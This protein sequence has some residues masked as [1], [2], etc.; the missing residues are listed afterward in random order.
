MFTNHRCTGGLSKNKRHLSRFRAKRLLNNR[1]LRYCS[2]N[3]LNGDGEFRH[4]AAN[5]ANLVNGASRLVNLKA[6]QLDIN[7]N[8]RQS[9]KR[10]QLTSAGGDE[11][12]KLS[13]E[14]LQCVA[15]NAKSNSAASTSAQNGYS[16]MSSSS[17]SPSSTSST[18]SLSSMSNGK[19]KSANNHH[20]HNHGHSHGLISNT[21]NNNSAANSSDCDVQALRNSLNNSSLLSLFSTALTT[22]LSPLSQHNINLNNFAKS[23]SQVNEI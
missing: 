11:A 5:A 12:S 21:N 19:E 17:A 16:P 9:L 4:L 13:D 7:R 22:A 1:R 14:A 23:Q 3:L 6:L 15:K 20:H 2:M 18:S 8:I 10:K